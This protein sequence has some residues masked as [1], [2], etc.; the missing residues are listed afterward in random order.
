[1]L[2]YIYLFL[3]LVCSSGVGLLFKFATTRK[4]NVLGTTMFYFLA[5]SVT[6]LIYSLF[7]RN[8]QI[9]LTL[10]GIGSLGGITA[11]GST[12]AILKA[13]QSGKASVFLTILGLSLVIP[14]IVSIVFWGEK[15]TSWNSLGLVLVCLSI[16]L[17]GQ[18]E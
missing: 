2:A 1:M 12:L 17:L 18:N 14:V 3:A 5:A 4:N 10:V 6:L 15:L 7:F 13:L 11:F 8:F 9:N 16:V